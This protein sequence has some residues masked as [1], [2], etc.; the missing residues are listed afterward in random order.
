MKAE[1]RKEDRRVRKT[2][3]QIEQ[4]LADLMLEKPVQ[5]I[6]VMELTERADINRGTF[7][8]HY[9]DIY[10]LL[11]EMETS[12]LDELKETLNRQ[13]IEDL[14]KDPSLKFVDMFRFLAE[15]RQLSYIVLNS[16]SEQSFLE[17]AKEALQESAFVTLTAL[18]GP[19]R[20]DLYDQFFTFGISGSI[21]LAQK[22]LQSGCRESPEEMGRMCNDF[23]E[24]GRSVLRKDKIAET[25]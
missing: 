20:Q 13:S 22:W 24:L 18:Y 17:A 15:H 23:L 2:R 14:K 7:Y 3:Q 1:A 21:G 8:L 4:T 5:E 6:T 10:D 9:R 19:G 12:L 16:Y 11:S 25:I